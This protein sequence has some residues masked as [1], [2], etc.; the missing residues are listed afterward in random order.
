VSVRPTATIAEL[1]RLL[2]RG[3][4]VG[5]RHPEPDD[6]SVLE[7]WAGDPVLERMTGSEF[8]RALR[9]TENQDPAFLAGSL[10][11]PTQVLMIVTDAEGGAPIGYVRLFGIHPRD[12]YA[13]LETIIADRPA[14]RRGCG[15]EAGK[16][17]CAWGL[18]V[19]GL[20][21]IEA[22]V[23]D[24]NLLSI[25]SLKRNGFHLEGVLR[26]A[27]LQGGQRCD[28]LVF[29]ILRDELEAQRQKESHPERFCFA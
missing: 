20:E 29:G 19:L 16:L 25:N 21:R 17:I 1:P 23:Y 4:R 7:R 11:D 27:G 8:L 15:V 26:K 6:Q 3:E 13:F 10:A 24:Y 14:L 5:L 9:H 18:D 22:K 28:V 2:P 12:G